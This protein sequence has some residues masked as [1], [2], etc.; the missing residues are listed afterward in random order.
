MNDKKIVFPAEWSLQSAVMITW[1]HDNT[2]WADM[3][4]EVEICFGE[5]AKSVLQYQKLI[6]I[7]QSE[8]RVKEFIPKNLQNN[9]VIINAD[10]NDTWARDHG[11]ICVF[12]NGRPFI[13]D[14]KFNGW[15][16]K[17]ASNKDNLITRT[18]YNN[19]CFND[20]V[21][22]DN[23]LGF[24][25]EGGSIE[26]DGKG[27]I[28]TTS[29]CLLSAN[30]N[31]D[32]NRDQIENYFK[33]TLGAKQVL[34][35]NNG[36]LSGDDTDSHIDTL[37][38]LCNEN[39]I[40]YVKCNNL[41]DEHYHA[42]K[43]MEDELKQLKTIDGKPYNLVALPM[44][45]EV[46]FDEHRLPATYANFLIINNAVLVPAYESEKDEEVKLIMKSVFPDRE[47]IMIDCLPLIK[48]H[49]SLHCVTMQF[50][51]SFIK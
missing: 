29:E 38:R 14:F 50:P 4:Y 18:M 32:L 43:N 21:G 3:L 47:I 44:A 41:N 42:L 40:A 26:S 28:L 35:L 7:C 37:A 30:R 8:K 11:P 12:K 39:T 17:F 31:G 20:I 19:G 2:D 15:G 22:Y 9:L 34:W 5:I 45:D 46:W 24:V 10:S 36:Y 51:V 25:L 16:L 6:V 13:L 1:P 49:G 27:T 48:Q 33:N 23:R